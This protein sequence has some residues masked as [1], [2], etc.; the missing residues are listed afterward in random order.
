MRRNDCPGYYVNFIS[1]FSYFYW[2]YLPSLISST[3]QRYTEHVRNIVLS[4]IL[5]S[6]PNIA[7]NIY[8]EARDFTFLMQFLILTQH[9]HFIP[10]L[11]KST[12]KEQQNL[13]TFWSIVKCSFPRIGSQEKNIYMKDPRKGF[14]KWATISFYKLCGG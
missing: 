10:S 1:G 11:F 6:W 8:P 3:V 9:I 5:A 2:R 14:W 7:L 13:V 12:Y 4:G